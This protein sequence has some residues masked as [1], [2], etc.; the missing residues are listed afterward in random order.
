MDWQEI[1]IDQMKSCYL[2]IRGTL[3]APDFNC[4]QI[5]TTELCRD[6]RAWGEIGT[7]RMHLRG[8]RVG[9]LRRRMPNQ[10]RSRISSSV[11]WG[12]WRVAQRL[13]RDLSP[14]KCRWHSQRVVGWESTRSRKHEWRYARRSLVQRLASKLPPWAIDDRPSAWWNWNGLIIMKGRAEMKSIPWKLWE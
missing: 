4:S 12:K 11:I 8:G 3:I 7:S 9:Q 6:V 1:Q 10:A 13:T 2:M 5:V 14:G